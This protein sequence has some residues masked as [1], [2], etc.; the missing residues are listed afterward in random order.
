[1]N[2]VDPEKRVPGGI[3][4]QRVVAAEGIGHYRMIER[5]VR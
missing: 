3:E 1:M 4:W 2:D 5:F